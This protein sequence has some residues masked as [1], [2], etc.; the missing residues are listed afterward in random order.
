LEKLDEIDPVKYGR[1]RNYV[2]GAV[3]CLSPYISRGVISTKQVLEV[4]LEKGYPIS[5]IESFV[6]ELCWRDYF[7]R[8][9]QVKDL[10][11]EKQ[12]L[13]KLL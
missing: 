2:N 1:T 5:E 7:Q 13:P 8:V 4:V 10:N 6:K 11:M 3:T 12:V 9:G